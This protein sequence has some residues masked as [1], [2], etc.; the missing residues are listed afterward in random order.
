M[1][2]LKTFLSIVF[3]GIG[4]SLSAQIVNNN[5]T[6]AVT[7]HHITTRMEL[8][9]LRTELLAQEIDFRY[10][11]KFDNNLSLTNISFTISA[12]DGQLTG[13]GEHNTMINPS[14]SLVFF[15]NK[16]AGTFS[17]ESHGEAPKH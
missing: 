5:G 14:A 12:N 6:I 16:T 3:I 17:V 10:T 2:S 7:I 11:P 4:C 8:S 15:V 1:N 9:T 13:A